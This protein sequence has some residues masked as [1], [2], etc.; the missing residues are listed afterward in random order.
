MALVRHILIY[1]PHSCLYKPLY[2]FLRF[3]H[4]RGPEAGE[5]EGIPITWGGLRY[6][7][8][9]LCAHNVRGFSLP[10]WGTNI[11]WCPVR[12]RARGTTRYCVGTC[13]CDFSIGLR[14]DS[15]RGSPRSSIGFCAPEKGLLCALERSCPGAPEVFREVSSFSPG[16][17]DDR[18]SYLPQDRISPPGAWYCLKRGAFFSVVILPAPGRW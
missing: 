6:I 10:W 3:Q 12:D 14:G 1:I 5:V 9:R 8:G 11:L 16:H 15:P 2:F 4:L 18:G 13:R 17:E 7:L